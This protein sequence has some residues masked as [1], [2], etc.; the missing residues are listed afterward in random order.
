M[1]L[2]SNRVLFII[3]RLLQIAVGLV[4]LSAALLKALD[5]DSFAEQIATYAIL[6]DLSLLAA[7][8]LII[9]E[10]ALATALIVNFLPRVVPL[11]TIA[12]LLFF[13]A[14]TVYG[15]MIGL[16]ESCGCFGNLVHRGPEQV[17]VE[18]ALMIVALVFAVIVLWGRKT[19][20]MRWR[21]A[22]SI[23]AA[24]IAALVTGVHAQLPVDDFVTQLKPG[25][26][27]STWP[28]DGLYGKDLNTGT[29]AV[30]LFTV[31]SPHVAAD[32]ERMNAIAQ[33]EDVPSAVGLIIDGTEHLTT[34]MFEYAA[35]FPVAAV[36][37]RFA[38]PLY[39][40]LPR[41]FVL[42]EGVVSATWSELPTPDRVVEAVRTA[43]NSS[44]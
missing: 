1:Q 5:P 38:R 25:A 3:A 32:V 37:P 18:D 31:R 21:A 17:I 22:L 41:V 39:R 19:A 2:S 44:R 6:P 4:F 23:S 30:F 14:I 42:H 9:F 26:V 28:V 20:G 12:M 10:V 13:I 15:M 24:A 43:T 40:R 27:F 29:H 7:W 35:A 8:T 36:E 16:G 33:H 11:L 34:L